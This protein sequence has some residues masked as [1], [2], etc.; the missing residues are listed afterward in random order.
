MVTDEY[1]VDFD[2]TNISTVIGYFNG[3]ILYDLHMFTHFAPNFS[4]SD[5][6]IGYAGLIAAVVGCQKLKPLPVVRSVQREL[7]DDSSQPNIMV[8]QQNGRI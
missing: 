3:M 2:L 6:A 4:L 1:G 7:A 8:D 5:Y